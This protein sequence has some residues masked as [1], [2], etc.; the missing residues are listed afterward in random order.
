MW[1]FLLCHQRMF[2][3]EQQTRPEGTNLVGSFGSSDFQLGTWRDLKAVE[4]PAGQQATEME[5]YT[6]E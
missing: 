1:D 6:N 3:S 2:S 4:R 5:N